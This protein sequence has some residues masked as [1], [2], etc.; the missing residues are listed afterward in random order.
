MIAMNKKIE[1]YKLPETMQAVESVILA[2][3][4]EETG[5]VTCD[6]AAIAALDEL[7]KQAESGISWYAK[8]DRNLQAQINVIGEEYEEVK[9]AMNEAMAPY[10]LEME[11]LERIKQARHNR[12]DFNKAV[13]AALF[14]QLG[15]DSLTLPSGKKVWTKVTESVQISP[16]IDLDAL[17]P[18]FVR[19]KK[20]L[21]KKAVKLAAKNGEWTS[22]GCEIIKKETIQFPK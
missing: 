9:A 11:R 12:R 5:E 4:D 19:I 8:M 3:M 21:D 15:V 6:P 10:L 7:S 14:K 1:L 2:S 17:D 18:A 16:D 13:V 20:E 22:P